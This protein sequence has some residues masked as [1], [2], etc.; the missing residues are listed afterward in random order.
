MGSQHS[1]DSLGE[2]CAYLIPKRMFWSQKKWRYPPTP[3]ETITC[4]SSVSATREVGPLER[5]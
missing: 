2:G 5:G 3:F 4:Q 1:T